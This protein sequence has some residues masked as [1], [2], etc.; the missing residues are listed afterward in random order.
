MKW[1]LCD[2]GDEQSALTLGCTA[3]CW[4]MVLQNRMLC[5]WTQQFPCWIRLCCFISIEPLTATHTRCFKGKP[6]VSTRDNNLL[7]MKLWLSFD[8]FNWVLN[9][10]LLH[11]PPQSS[12]ASVSWM[13]RMQSALKC[14]PENFH[15]GVFNLPYLW[16][17]EDIQLSEGILQTLHCSGLSKHLFPSASWSSCWPPR[18]VNLSAQSQSWTKETQ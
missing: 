11:K 17:V 18:M 5:S 9:L 15:W 14:A 12:M 3:S 4:L 1:S 2:P 16:V 13:Q 7:S 6:L 8:S 10:V